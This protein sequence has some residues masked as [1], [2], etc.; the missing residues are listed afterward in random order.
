MRRL[1]RVALPALLLGAAGP[2][3]AAAGCGDDSGETASNQG[4]GGFSG[5]AGSGGTGGADAS[6]SASG[7]TGAII[8]NDSPGG[9][10]SGE[11]C[12]DGG[13]CA[14]GVCC[15]AE[16]ACGDACCASAEVCSFGSCVV[17]GGAC[18][19]P[20]DCTADEYCD[21]ALGPGA[22]E[23]GAPD[24]ACVGGAPVLEGRCM[25]KPPVCPDADA[26][27]PADAGPP[28]CLE[29]C[30]VVPPT[31]SFQA[32]EKYAW[33]GEVASPWSSDVMMTP[34]VV[35]LDDDDCDGQV[36][37]RDIPEIL[38]TTFAAGAYTTTGT[39][40]AI[41]IVG[42]AI[43]DRWSLPGV[44]ASRQLAGG[45][46][47][48]QPGNEVVGC[49]VDGSSVV[50]VRGDGTP[51]WTTTQAILCNQPALADLDQDGTPEVIVEGGV[52]DGATGGVETTF[53]PA[54]EGTFAV[55]DVTGDGE[56]DVVTNTNVYDASG[57][58][59]ATN[60]GPA[61][62][63]T[64]GTHFESGPA[65][66]DL[67][68]DGDPEIVS[69]YFYQHQ[70]AIWRYDASKPGS[71][72]VV[73]AGIDINGP[74]NPSLCAPGSAGAKWGGGP[75]TVGDFDGDGT[76]DVALAGGV[77]YAVFDGKKLMDPAVADIDT[78]L[79]TRQTTD[80]S[81][82]GTGSSL[83]DFNG[84][85]K[86][87]VIY[88]DEFAF[89]IYAGDT[90]DV[91]FETC[92]TSGT[93]SEFPLVADVDSD[94][95][96]DIV[97]ASNAYAYQCPGGGTGTSGIRV[98]GSAAGT[99]VRTRR[100]WNQHA[101]QITNVGEDGSIPAVE[102]PNWSA[103]GLNNFRLNRQPGSEFAAPNAVVE[104][105]VRCEGFALVATVRNVGEALLP[106]GVVVDFFLGTPPGGTSLGQGTTTV[107]LGP[108]QAEQVV[109]PLATPPPDLQNG[110]TPAYARLSVPPPTVQ[111]REDDDT[112]LPA[113]ARCGGP[114]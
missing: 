105:R 101:Y 88:A 33:G 70:L 112:S 100:V 57:A 73:R 30:E 40:H 92:N 37:E 8:G 16:R 80:C 15:E 84:D 4:A 113:S 91:L 60:A 62:S 46:I 106:A 5:D 29:K 109:L 31:S 19:D 3:F 66:A 87:E 82:A 24:A 25:P 54:M 39:L 99:W 111:C 2:A 55:A 90:G 76:P 78:L 98:F 10:S 114:F 14:G 52:L 45:N 58:Q 110:T 94:G 41:S 89:R 75:A 95:Q 6:D 20:A 69:V 17:P 72:D 74:L 34:I 67:D 26:G 35:N 108:A 13:I 53:T 38:F 12:G 63:W 48:G 77:G 96:A 93:L 61:H 79:W 64:G 11:P 49:G 104:V 59:I 56:L 50:A 85:G 23:A 21:F 102:S 43:V 68:L 71:A 1:R 27:A 103:K 32:V 18:T 107:P 65:V 51:F 9:C 28:S 44:A 36:T 22:A 42:G 97:V 86:A 83:F 47:D 81:S 7:G